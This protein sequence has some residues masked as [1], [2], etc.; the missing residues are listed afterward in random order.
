MKFNKRHLFNKHR[1]IEERKNWWLGRLVR[2]ESNTETLHMKTPLTE[3]GLVSAYV[4]TSIG[5]YAK[6]YFG[7][8]EESSWISI[9]YLL[10]QEEK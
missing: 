9:L 4:E 1:S 5:Q 8:I 7:S 3:V 6:V 10:T 2:V